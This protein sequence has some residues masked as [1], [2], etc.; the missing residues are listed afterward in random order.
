M[1]VAGTEKQ[2]E[3]VRHDLIREISQ[4]KKNKKYTNEIVLT[5]A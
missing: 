4:F 3:P 1:M 5:R 2:S